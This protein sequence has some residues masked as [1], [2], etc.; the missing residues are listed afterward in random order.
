MTS[1]LRVLR[2][3]DSDFN[4]AARES[5]K[6]AII[7][8]GIRA[9]RV[10]PGIKGRTCRSLATL[11]QDRVAWLWPVSSEQFHEYFMLAD[12]DDMWRR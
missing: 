6:L 8:S 3:Q 9:G 5:R 4:G 12:Y 1:H 7:D 10:V 11:D 2:V